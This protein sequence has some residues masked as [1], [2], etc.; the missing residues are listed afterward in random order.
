MKQIG[1]FLTVGAVNTLVGLSVIF[2]CMSLL[3]MGLA[4]ANALGYAVGVALSFQL[5]RNWTFGHDGAW[6]SAFARWLAV[7]ALSY[8]CNL[9]AAMTAWTLGVNAYLAQIVGVAVY[10]AVSY[11][12]AKRFAFPAAQ[13]RARG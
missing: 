9:A 3:G 12:G 4:P 7:V 6:A 1:R 8:A 11:G 13:A 2:A 5:N 10:S